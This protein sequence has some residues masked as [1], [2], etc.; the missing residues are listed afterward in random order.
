[1]KD[2]EFDQAL[3]GTAV[4][5]LDN[6][7]NVCLTLSDAFTERGKEHKAAGDSH[8]A[9]LC[10]NIATRLHG[11]QAV[12]KRVLDKAAKDVELVRS[13]VVDGTPTPE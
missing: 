2:W 11:Y 8:K 9:G 5:R 4:E 1:M 12:S 6:G 7:K 13:R 3:W 10:F